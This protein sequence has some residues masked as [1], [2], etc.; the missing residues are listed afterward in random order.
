MRYSSE[1]N[2][3]SKILKQKRVRKYAIIA[4]A[5]VITIS[6][7]LGFSIENKDAKLADGQGNMAYEQ[8]DMS[9]GQGS[10]ISSQGIA[11]SSTDKNTDIFNEDELTLSEDK[12]AGK[13]AKQTDSSS[14]IMPAADSKLTDNTKPAADKTLV[15]ESK[16]KEKQKAE[17][18]TVTL[19]IRCDALSGHMEYLENEAIRGYIPE[20]GIILAKTEYEGTTDNTAFDALNTL[21]R[22]NN[23]QLEFNYT[24]AYES[25]YIEGINYLYELDAGP[26]S[27]WMF[28]VNDRF[29]NN[30]CSSYH[31]SDGDEIVFTYTCRDLGKDVGNT[32]W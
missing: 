13:T 17:N 9:Y 18:V 31:L 26:L 14:D 20:D 32:G 8:S 23:I 3:F 10:A 15:D 5:F 30:G 28:K 27:G 4:L 7:L 6:I 25:Y 21:C 12:T 24:P 19:E 29:P 2:S 1:N 16:P 11:T 22:N